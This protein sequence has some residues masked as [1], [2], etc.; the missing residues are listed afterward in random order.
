MLEKTLE[1]PLDCK[2]IQSVR[3]PFPRQ[4]DNKS[5]GPQGGRG[6]E[7]SRRRKGKTFLSAFLSLSQLHKSV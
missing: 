1:S 6:L 4:V 2:E 3:E 7:F 5:R